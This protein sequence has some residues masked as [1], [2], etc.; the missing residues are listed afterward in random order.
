MQ[1]IADIPEVPQDVRDHITGRMAD[2]GPEALHAEL[3]R[4]DPVSA[5]RI[6]PRDMQR[7]A[8]ALEVLEATGR[9]LSGYQAEQPFQEAPANV[10]SVGF[11][12]ERAEL[13][14]HLDQRVIQM[15][16][17]GLIDEV[18]EILARGYATDL[19]PLK[20]IGY[21]EVVAYLQSRLPR[22]ELAAAIQLRTR[23]YAPDH[24]VQASSGSGVGAGWKL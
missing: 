8:R 12:W 13:Y 18:K 19:K 14:R 15:L 9:P 21:L 23:H 11:A 17:D 6:Q 16:E 7:I 10:L 4:K 24:L 5:Q 1:G 3:V 20:A 22:E 2:E